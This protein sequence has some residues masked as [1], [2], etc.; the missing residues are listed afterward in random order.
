MNQGSLHEQQRTLGLDEEM[1]SEDPQSAVDFHEYTRGICSELGSLEEKI[2]SLSPS[3]DGKMKAK[4]GISITE[5]TTEGEAFLSQNE[6][7]SSDFP[8]LAYGYGQ[9][10]ATTATTSSD[11]HDDPSHGSDSEGVG[12]Q[13]PGFNFDRLA[14]ILSA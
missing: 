11:L 13:H 12:S 4:G 14:R 9:A 2:L 8:S 5:E 1:V 3:D 7:T 10:G 6:V